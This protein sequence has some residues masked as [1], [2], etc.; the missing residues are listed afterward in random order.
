M[1]AWQCTPREDSGEGTQAIVRATSRTRARQ[2]ADEY[3]TDGERNLPPGWLGWNAK[4]LKVADGEGDLT[5]I[6]RAEFPDYTVEG[7]PWE[8]W[9]LEERTTGDGRMFGYSA[10]YSEK[11]Q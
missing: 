3:W 1:K 6:L 9:W 8:P 10:H 5:E 2:I 7:E 11:K 4:R